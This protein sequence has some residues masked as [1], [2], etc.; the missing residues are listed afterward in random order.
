MTKEVARLT[1]LRNY[2]FKEIH[3]IIPDSKINGKLETRLPNNVNVCIPNIDAEFAVICLDETGVACS[4][5][6]TC[7]NTSNESYSYVLERIYGDKSCA[8]SSLRFSL[9][10]YTTKAE[11]D[12]CVK[13]LKRVL[14]LQAVSY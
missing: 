10:R 7:M 4:S 11:I 8:T 1:K 5:A 14:E 9:G 2:F 3:K 12:K 6:S 13:I